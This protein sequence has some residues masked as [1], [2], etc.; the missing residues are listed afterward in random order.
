MPAKL[1]TILAAA[2]LF[3]AGSAAAQ[4]PKDQNAA[5]NVRQSQQYEQMLHSNRSFRARR[6]AEECG[7]INDK[8]MHQQCIAS[9]GGDA[10][11]PMHR[12]A[13]NKH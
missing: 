13:A 12:P 10:P 9:F 3:A 5:Q 1:S 8:E 11:A 6:M 2:L 7:P 4:M